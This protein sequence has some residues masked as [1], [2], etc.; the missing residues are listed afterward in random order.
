MNNWNV[1]FREKIKKIF[2]EKKQ[3]I[4][5]GGGLRISK[6]K[7][8]RFDEEREKWIRPYLSGVDYKVL[9]KVGDYNPDIIGDVHQLPF[10]DSS[11]E[12]IICIAVLQHVEN[13]ILASQEIYRV[14]KEN[15]YAFIY[16]PFLYYYH[17]MPGYYKDYWRFTI[18]SINYIF[19]DFKS[20]QIMPIRGAVGTLIR[21]SPLGRYKFFE[22]I[23]FYID[24]LFN[25]LE[26]NQVSG[27][28]IFLIK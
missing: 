18:D 17:A 23:C 6:E 20:K 14:L 27:Y 10:K 5:I 3:I 26:S 9:D 15:G 22:K 19:K 28:Y 12:A 21:L 2:T 4:D 1:F 7:S 8:N 16:V 24:K 11:V 25:K 13:P